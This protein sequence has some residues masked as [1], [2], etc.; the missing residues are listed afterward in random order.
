MGS[1]GAAATQEQQLWH[2]ALQAWG[3]Q[4]ESELL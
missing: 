3:L 2:Q 1:Q 4:A